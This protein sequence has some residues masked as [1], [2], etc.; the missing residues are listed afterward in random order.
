MRIVRAEEAFFVLFAG[1][2]LAACQT[3]TGGNVSQLPSSPIPEVGYDAKVSN[4]AVESCRSA[5]TAQTQGG[6]DVVASEFSQANVTIYMTVGPQRAPW[7]CLVSNSGAGP[8]LEYLGTN[9]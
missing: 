9:G 5:L 8:E 4:A 7:K 3:D 6:V 1:V 2:A